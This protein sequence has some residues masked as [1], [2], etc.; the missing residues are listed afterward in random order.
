MGSRSSTRRAARSSAWQVEEKPC[1]GATTAFDLDMA[2]VG[3]DDLAADVQPEP[4]SL[5]RACVLRPVVLVEHC[6]RVASCHRNTDIAHRDA[7]VMLERLEPHVD[8]SVSRSVLE[9]VGD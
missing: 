1:S 4:G 9:R 7:D 6:P 8:A 5:V 3:L 2:A